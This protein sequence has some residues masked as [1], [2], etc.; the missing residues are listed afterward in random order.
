MMVTTEARKRRHELIKHY[1]DKFCGILEQL[2]FDKPIPTL[3][4]LNK[5]IERFGFFGE[6]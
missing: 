4:D 2:E 3:E 6:K 5:E 1:H